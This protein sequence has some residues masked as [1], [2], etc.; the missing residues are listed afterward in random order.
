MQLRPGIIS[1][2]GPSPGWALLGRLSPHHRIR[3]CPPVD[4]SG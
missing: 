2:S 1:D 4:A 3:I